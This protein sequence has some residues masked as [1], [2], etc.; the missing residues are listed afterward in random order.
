VTAIDMV[1]VSVTY[2]E[3]AVLSSLTARVEPG[4]WVGLLGPN[5]AGKT[6]LL[7]AIAGLVASSG[8]IRIDGTPV[9]TMSRRELARV[10]AYV[11]QRPV[12]PPIMA[13][14]DYV[15]IGRTP[16]IPYLGL[17]THSDL[18]IVGDVLER[19][20][21]QPLAGR[22]LGSLSGGEVQRAV[23]ARALAQS[24]PVLLLDEPTAALD[25]GHQQQ[26]LE[27]IDQLR[28]D[29]RLTVVS[30]MHDLTLA[31]QFADRLVLLSGGKAIAEGSARE[32]LTEERIREHYGASTRVLHD[33]N[34]NVL[35]VPTRPTTRTPTA[36]STP[37]D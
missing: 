2:D 8:V 35:V 27:L 30:A 12:I 32:V 21:L 18:A 10:V 22:P 16:H 11:P 5:G 15:L 3:V 4:S 29:H 14:T 20:E 24:A 19:L 23:L 33:E 9:V 34:G 7:R 13:V 6:T 17:E 37:T 26:V 25:V 28:I 1:D 36:M 31:G